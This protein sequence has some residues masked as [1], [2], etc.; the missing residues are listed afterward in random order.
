M[1]TSKRQQSRCTHALRAH[2]TPDDACENASS[3]D[4]HRLSATNDRKMDGIGNYV[5]HNSYSIHFATVCSAQLM[6]INRTSVFAGFVAVVVGPKCVRTAA[7]F[8]F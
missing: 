4:K 5:S 7:L 1:F 2:N 3:D 6:L 8:T